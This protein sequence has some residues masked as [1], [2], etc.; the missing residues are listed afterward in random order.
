MR[1][2]LLSLLVIFCL[3]SNCIPKGAVEV[4]PDTHLAA[5]A[6]VHASAASPQAKS[7][8]GPAVSQQAVLSTVRQSA[9]QQKA[10]VKD[11]EQAV[12]NYG[13]PPRTQ[14]VIVIVAG[15]LAFLIFLTFIYQI[16]QMSVLR[17]AAPTPPGVTAAGPAEI[18]GRRI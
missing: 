6:E 2:H 9:E 10:Y 4:K 17:A 3:G 15:V 11:V 7:E 8:D 1:S 18:F 12:I 13:I 5:Q 14:I 16:R